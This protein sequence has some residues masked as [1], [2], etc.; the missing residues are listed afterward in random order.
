MNNND[1]D[2]NLQSLSEEQ[3]LQGLGDLVRNLLVNKRAAIFVLRADN[4]VTIVDPKVIREIPVEALVTALA[5]SWEEA[6]LEEFLAY[7]YGE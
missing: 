1:S 7:V 5:D 3:V 6:D 2:I 4:A